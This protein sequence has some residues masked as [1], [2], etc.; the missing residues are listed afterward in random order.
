MRVRYLS[1]CAMS[2]YCFYALL[3]QILYPALAIP[4]TLTGIEVLYGLADPWFPALISFLGCAAFL[5][6][7]KDENPSWQLGL[8]LCLVFAITALYPLVG[9]ILV[10]HDPT[11]PIWHPGIL[12]T[13]VSEAA[14]C[15][16]PP[17]TALFFWSQRALGGRWVPV[18]AAIALIVTI[19]SMA[20]LWAEYTP[21]LVSAGLIP[22]A[23]P[24]ML[25]GQ[26]VRMEND[27][28]LILYL[29]FGLPLIGILFLILAA[30]SWS[31]SA[32]RTGGASGNPELSA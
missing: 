13:L 7:T 26:P 22:P 32:G 9:G 10:I 20:M 18:L 15:L 31:A 11:P 30:L 4:A 6:E 16:I 1:L 3:L 5:R 29:G 12:W 25:N 17:C 19:S 8:P 28:P 2:V 14:V 24:A 27:G 21:W 23:Q